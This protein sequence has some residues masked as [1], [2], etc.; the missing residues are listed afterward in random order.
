MYII[1]FIVQ[2]LLNKRRFNVNFTIIATLAVIFGTAM[3][4][5][6]MALA[7]DITCSRGVT[8]FGTLGPDNMQGTSTADAMNARLGDDNMNGFAAN[9]LMVGGG[10]DDTMNG[11]SGR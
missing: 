10:D 8:C 9:D 4:T 2:E 6:N 7:D 5:T 3:T 1:L 11:G